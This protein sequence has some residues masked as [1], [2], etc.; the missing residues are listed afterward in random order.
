[1]SYIYSSNLAKE[2]VIF[3]SIEKAPVGF[4][5][6]IV[7]S[8]KKNEINKK[9]FILKKKPPFDRKGWL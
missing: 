1:M 5:K 8:N 2:I 4:G 7:Q 6:A 9:R 3:G